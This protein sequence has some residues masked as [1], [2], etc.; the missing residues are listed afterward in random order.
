MKPPPQKGIRDCDAA[1]C[2][3]YVWFTDPQND[4]H[5]GN[6]ARR[7]LLNSTPGRMELQPILE[8]V[9]DVW[10]DG[11]KPTHPNDICLMAA[12][13]R[14]CQGWLEAYCDIW[15]KKT[16]DLDSIQHSTLYSG[17]GIE[18]RFFAYWWPAFE[19]DSLD[20]VLPPQPQ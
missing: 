10:L 16:S 7:L 17:A 8:A 19:R 13:A 4:D 11:N 2:Q 3:W 9:L 14:L 18:S 1:A 6:T 12:T 20:T 15:S 5:T